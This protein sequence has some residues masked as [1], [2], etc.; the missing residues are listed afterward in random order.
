VNR[1][2]SSRYFN[3]HSGRA[4]TR[5]LLYAAQL[6]HKL[7]FPVQGLLQSRAHAV[8]VATF[9]SKVYST[10]S[11]LSLIGATMN[12]LAGDALLRVCTDVTF[13]APIDNSV[14]PRPPCTE[15]PATTSSHPLHPHQPL[16]FGVIAD[17]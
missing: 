17:W 13:Y 14:W 9:L 12:L 5:L 8:T 2:T 3:A 10:E 4:C 16:Q 15:S 1:C 7:V 11:K 6:L